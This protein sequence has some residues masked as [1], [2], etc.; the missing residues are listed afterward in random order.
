MLRIGCWDVTHFQS[1]LHPHA[2]SGVGSWLGHSWV[3]HSPGTRTAWR[4]GG[5]HL[6]HTQTTDPSLSGT[7]TAA[8]PVK[9]GQLTC[10][11]PFPTGKGISHNLPD[12]VAEPTMPQEAPGGWQCH[13]LVWRGI[14]TRANAKQR[15]GFLLHLLENTSKLLPFPTLFHSH[16]VFFPPH[17]KSP[18]FFG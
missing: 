13:S 11:L 7:S 12:E 8:F 14:N 6:W 5:L 16:A 2:K 9:A 10:V 18:D 15:F 3:W 1:Q 4:H 17:A